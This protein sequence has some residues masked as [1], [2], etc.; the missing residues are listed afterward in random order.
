[1]MRRLQEDA[2]RNISHEEFRPVAKRVP[3]HSS[4]LGDVQ[5]GLPISDTTP[6]DSTES[7]KTALALLGR[8]REP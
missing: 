2:L 3:L 6:A 5:L 8:V 7:R 1:M 4:R